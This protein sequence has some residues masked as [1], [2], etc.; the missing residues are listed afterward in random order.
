MREDKLLGVPGDAGPDDAV[1]DEV[2]GDL[3]GA[4][5]RGE[6]NLTQGRAQ[7]ADEAKIGHSERSDICR[8]IRDCRGVPIGGVE[9]GGVLRARLPGRAAGL[10]RGRGRADRREEKREMKA[11]RHDEILPI[12]RP[13]SQDCKRGEKKKLDRRD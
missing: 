2:E 6:I 5:I 3:V 12:P 10:K 9:P 1:Q 11:S 13:E 4:R 8:T 7:A